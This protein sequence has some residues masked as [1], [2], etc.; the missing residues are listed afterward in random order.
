MAVVP[1]EITAGGVAVYHAERDHGGVLPWAAVRFGVRLEAGRAE[2]DRGALVLPCPVAGCGS[3]TLHQ[4]GDAAPGA[5]RAAL[6]ALRG[7][8][9][10]G[11]RPAT[12]TERAETAERTARATR[13][14]KLDQ[15]IAG[16][17]GLTAAERAAAQLNTM[18]IVRAVVRRLLGE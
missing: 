9:P 4:D 16:F 15:D 13:L 10:E 2:D 14:A 12:D 1:V 11:P 8:V 18:V 5:V 6:A 3:E 17:A 7:R